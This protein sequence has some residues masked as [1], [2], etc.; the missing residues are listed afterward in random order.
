MFIKRWLCRKN[1]RSIYLQKT[2][3]SKNMME[4]SKTFFKKFLKG[5]YD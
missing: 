5:K 1:G 4:D 3:F 2:P